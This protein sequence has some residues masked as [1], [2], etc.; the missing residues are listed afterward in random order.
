MLEGITVIDLSDGVAGAMAAML[1]ADNGAD[2]VDVE[3]AGGRS[4]AP[5][6]GRTVW[7]RG[8]RSAILDRGVAAD[9]HTLRALVARADV[10]VDTPGVDDG[11][12]DLWTAAPPTVVRASITGYGRGVHRHAGRPAVDALVAARMGLHWDQRGAYGGLPAFIAGAAGNG[13]GPAPAA[14]VVPDGAEQ[15]GHR[16]GPIFL[17]LPWPSIGAALLVTTGI[18]AAL[19][20]RETTGRG[21]RVETSLLQGGLLCTVPTW[22]RVPNPLL[23]GYRL[24]YFDRR[25]PKGFFRCADGRWVHQWAPIEHDFVQAAVVGGTLRMPTSAEVADVR[26]KAAT[27]A[28]GDAG[29]A[30]DRELARELRRHP[31]TAAA[32]ALHPSSEWVE[33]FARAGKPCQ[34]VRS[35]EEGLGDPWSLA[36]GCVAEVADAGLGPIRQV[37]LVYRLAETPGRVGRGAPVPGAQTAEVRA[38]VAA[39]PTPI[40]NAA[41]RPLAH[42]LE[43]VRVIDLGMAM[44]G[45]YGTQTLADLGATRDQDS[46]SGRAACARLQSGHRVQPRQA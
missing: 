17:G 8:K 23:E 26:A 1:L 43:G 16:D 31:A 21:Q 29:D 42:A 38:K 11:L 4:F 35:P 36:E 20:A 10:V 14:P 19:L 44:A 37:G 13:F 27:E 5:Y 12:E 15:T 32:F 28:E 7:G 41:P 40:V 33:L 34:P 25:H 2:V 30:Y 9:R 3:P 39:P 46:Q 6:G 22:Q 45:P 18:S 24:P